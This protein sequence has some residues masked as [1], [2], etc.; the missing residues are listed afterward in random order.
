M[1]VLGYKAA[2]EQFGPN[3]LLD[4]VIE[5][6][7]WGFD[8]ISASDHF[9]PWRNDD[10]RCFF[11]WSWLGTLGARTRRVTFGTGVTAPIL[12][13]NPAVLAE[14]SATL[15]AQF[16]G[17]FWLGLGTG[18]AL[19]DRATTGE[20]PD[21]AERRGRLEEAIEIMRRLW[22]GEHLT[23]RG[24]YFQTRAAH[25]YVQSAEPIPLL[26]AAMGPSSARLV[27]QYA[28]G[29]MAT[30]AAGAREPYAALW[31]SVE[32]GARAGGR[33]PG[34]IQRWIELEVVYAKDQAQG[35]RDARRWD[36][37]LVRDRD[38]Y[39]IYDPRDLQYYGGLLPDATVRRNWLISDDPAAHVALAEVYIQLGFTHLFFHHPGLDQP[40]FL[41]FYGEQVLPV[42]RQ[43]YGGAASQQAPAA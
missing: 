40:A 8:A 17:R 34:T 25:L 26:V 18:E 21:Y 20:W 27:G 24:K 28:D 19:N 32:A 9:H 39:G 4:Y 12:R 36:G 7:H 11:V 14:A 1:L 37:T 22:A 29:W 16:P 15:G 3:E 43:K 30:G 23:Y 5:A 31:P 13:Y 10:V 42:L 35:L 6:E 2:T 33:D 41:R 38:K